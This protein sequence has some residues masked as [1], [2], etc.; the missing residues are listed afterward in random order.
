VSRE[1][2]ETAF[3]D[4]WRIDSVEPSTIDATVD[5]NGVQAWLVV[6]TRV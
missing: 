4:G 1:G 2:L 5:P 3:A 6:L